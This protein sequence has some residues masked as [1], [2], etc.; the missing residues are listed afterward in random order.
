[1]QLWE[2]LELLEADDFADCS[3][4]H[5]QEE[6]LLL[7]KRHQPGVGVFRAGL[8]SNRLAGFVLANH[9]GA[10]GAVV[11]AVV[12]VGLVTFLVLE[13]QHAD[14][15]CRRQHLHAH[16]VDAAALLRHLHLVVVWC[17]HEER[18]RPLLARA[19]EPHLE[20]VGSR[21][22]RP[23]E[24]RLLVRIERYQRLRSLLLQLQLARRLV[25]EDVVRHESDHVGPPVL[26]RAPC[27]S[28][29]VLES[30]RLAHAVGLLL[31]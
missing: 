13:E 7:G 15:R 21:W 25:D 9:H 26:A 5:L 19:Q 23:G 12:S 14:A 20:M 29:R 24:G 16:Q 1:M 30:A 18:V 27:A 22:A 2:L 17:I 8:N 10:A 6:L 28:H 4:R 31:R 3:V 11:D